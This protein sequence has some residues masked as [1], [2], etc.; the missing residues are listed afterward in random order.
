MR[1]DP[2]PGVQLPITYREPLFSRIYFTIVLILFFLTI[3]LQR[4]SPYAPLFFL[5]WL[6]IFLKSIY[7]WTNQT[8]EVK[9]KYFKYNFV[10]SLNIKYKYPFQIGSFQADWD[11][12]LRV[13]VYF[14]VITIF[15]WPS[16]LVFTIKNKNEKGSICINWLLLARKDLREFLAILKAKSPQAIF[17][18]DVLKLMK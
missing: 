4:S 3:Y 7:E 16:H 13:E 1:G 14:P 8:L 9:E 11:E 17:E 15:Q 12:I 5:I 6:V 18:L 2:M 10:N